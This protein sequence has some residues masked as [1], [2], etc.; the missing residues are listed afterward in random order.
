[1]RYTH[2]EYLFTRDHRTPEEIRAGKREALFGWIALIVFSAVV[3][4]GAKLLFG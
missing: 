1:M 3:L 2:H 4:A